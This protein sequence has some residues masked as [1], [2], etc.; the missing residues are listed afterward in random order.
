MRALLEDM[1]G[2]EV[3]HL[4]V[5][6]QHLEVGVLEQLRVA[7]AQALAD[8]LLHARVVQLALACRLAGNQLVDRVSDG[9][10]PA[11]DGS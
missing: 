9:A 2:E 6:V 4:G 3:V 8:G 11:A 1:L 10:A 5:V 7:F